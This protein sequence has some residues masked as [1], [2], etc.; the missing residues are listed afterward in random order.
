[1]AGVFEY[2]LGS[3]TAQKEI[4]GVKLAGRGRCVCS[5][6]VV[7]LEKFRGVDS[8]VIETTKAVH[9][10]EQKH[11]KAQIHMERGLLAF[12]THADADCSLV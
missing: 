11:S 8:T 1:M 3:G 10:P 9:G 2:S 6:F 12:Q 5:N 4:S 7:E